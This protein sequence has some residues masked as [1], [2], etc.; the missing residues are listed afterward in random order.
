[1]GGRHHAVSHNVS[2]ISVSES[3]ADKLIYYLASISPH[4]GYRKHQLKYAKND[5]NE[6]HLEFLETLFC[7]DVILMSCI[8]RLFW[9]S[10]FSGVIQS[11]WMDAVVMN[12]ILTGLMLSIWDMED[13]LHF[14][15][16]RDYQSSQGCQ[17]GL[18]TSLLSISKHTRT[19]LCATSYVAKLVSNKSLSS[20]STFQ[21]L[22]NLCNN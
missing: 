15:V 5:N 19:K 13:A 1:M 10:L 9:L 21:R 11:Y 7:I 20:I 4:T 3:G 6:L 18:N 22:M 12:F 17:R 14:L 2:L 16:L 8:K